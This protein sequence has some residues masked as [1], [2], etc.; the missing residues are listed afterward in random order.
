[1]EG[2]LNRIF[3]KLRYRPFNQDAESNSA[4]KG[5]HFYKMRSTSEQEHT[6]NTVTEQLPIVSV[7]G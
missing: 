7:V 4:G 2:E 3:V 5:F 1:M 6:A